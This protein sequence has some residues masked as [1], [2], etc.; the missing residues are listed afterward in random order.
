MFEHKKFFLCFI[1]FALQNFMF[2]VYPVQ[3]DALVIIDTLQV[4]AWVNSNSFL[5]ILNWSIISEGLGWPEFSSKH[6]SSASFCFSLPF[7]MIITTSCLAMLSSIFTNVRSSFI[8]PG[9]RQKLRLCWEW[10]HI[11]LFALLSTAWKVACGIGC[12]REASLV[13]NLKRKSRGGIENLF[14]FA[15]Q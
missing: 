8:I 11:S 3:I 1:A 12:H 4:F 10:C 15:F 14:A 13:K 6:L 7:E 9:S 5:S 2:G